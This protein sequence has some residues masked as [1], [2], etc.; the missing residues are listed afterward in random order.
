MILLVEDEDAVAE[1]I[2]ALLA[3]D[4]WD[5]LRVAGVEEALDLSRQEPR[6]EPELAIIDIKLADGDGR[7]LG[8]TLRE[9]SPHLPILFISGHLRARELG[10]IASTGRTAFLQKPFGS[11]ALSETIN[12]LLS[13]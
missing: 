10:P 5:V 12:R 1:G 7:E 9:T 2:E 8:A 6:Q 13:T 4:G 3:L 11:T